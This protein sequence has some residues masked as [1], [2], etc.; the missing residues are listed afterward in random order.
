MTTFL[1]QNMRKKRY[2]NPFKVNLRLG[3]EVQSDDKI[4]I[5]TKH[6]LNG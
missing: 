6:K 3:N 2:D 4:Y 1:I 5:L